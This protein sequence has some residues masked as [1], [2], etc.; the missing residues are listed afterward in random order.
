MANTIKVVLLMG[1]MTGLAIAVGFLI[2]GQAGMLVAFGI[3]EL[4]N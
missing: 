4:I 2:G 1:L 3:L